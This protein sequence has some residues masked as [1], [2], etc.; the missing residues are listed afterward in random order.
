MLQRYRILRP[1]EPG[2]D[3]RVYL[4]S[5]RTEDKSRRVLTLLARAPFDE[6][7][8]L[9]QL[10]ELFSLRKSL[11]HS[12]LVP[13]RD[14]AFRGSRPGLV[15]DFL[16]APHPSCER[17]ELSLEIALSLMTQLAELIC[18]LHN[19]HY[20]C[21]YVKPAHLFVD[22]KIRLVA[23]L[24]FPKT[25]LGSKHL[26]VESIR[27][28][29]PEHLIDKGASESGDIYSLGMVMY[30]FF[31]GYQPFVE[32]NLIAL[33][34]KQLLTYPARPR[35]LNPDIP[36]KIEQLILE[37][38]EKDPETRPP[39]AD[40]VVSMLR[41]E[42]PTAPSAVPKFTSQLVGRE[43][44]LSF[45]RRFF[46]S[47][48]KSPSTRF[49]AISSSSGIGKTA[50]T[51]HLETIAKSRKTITLTIS[52]HQGG[53]DL[54]G[55]DLILAYKAQGKDVATE[56]TLLASD[57]TLECFIESLDSLSS[58]QRVVL[59]LN[60]LHWMDEAALD[61]YK[62]IVEKQL[63]A[64]FICSCRCDELATHWK[65]LRQELKRQ[66]ILTELQLEP[67]VKVEAKQLAASLL[68]EDFDE[69]LIDNIISPCRGNPF[70]IHE[71]LRHMQ[72]LG[73]LV[74]VGG[75][76]HWVYQS[77]KSGSL[78]K[79]V[80][81]QIQGRLERLG[82]TELQAIE[83][84][85]LVDNP[86]AVSEL[87]GM[88]RVSVTKALET[89]DALNRLEFVTIS[90]TLD[91]PITALKHDWIGHAA[92]TRLESQPARKHKMHGRIASV[93]AS[94]STAVQMTPFRFEPPARI[95]DRRD[96]RLLCFHLR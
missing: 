12:S 47:H 2:P 9:L 75:S 36:V 6:E 71:S 53:V 93:L 3:V 78:P 61:F 4:L 23:N 65:H 96:L 29:A 85:S 28:S 72:K 77:L 31:T 43:D 60:D 40:Y 27:Y 41:S 5:D 58:E 33:R 37:M 7:E 24:L 56:N 76:W 39:S 67:L 49:L 1:L 44:E 81:N 45:F 62:A 38:I 8:N 70:Y 66:D 13:V 11:D 17:G 30:Y 92:Q 91:R 35:K 87:A 79:T 16:T 68:G 22:S 10:E 42:K 50:L 48:L 86:I 69:A 73:N 57:P 82:S 55:F 89:L 90:G 64:L 51:N 94:I 54:K 63:P 32:Q 26:D 25:G 59:F 34:Q 83:Y 20:Y 14:L 15:S 21:G 19:R 18:Y 88:M 74:F 84:V 52:H 46:E 95:L 80:A